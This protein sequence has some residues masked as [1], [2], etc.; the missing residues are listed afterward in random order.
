[1]RQETN[2]EIDLMLRRMSRRDGDSM[3]DEH[4]QFDDHHLDADELSSY[5]QNALPPATRARYTE[6]LAD[7]STCRKIATQLAL[8]LGTTV[9]ASAETVPTAGGLKAFLAGLFSPM[10]L[11]YAVPALGLIVV[12]VIGFVVLRQQGS[13]EMAS[14]TD[15]AE[16]KVPIVA[17]PK[18][19]VT[20]PLPNDSASKG[21][22]D[23]QNAQKQ[24]AQQP[25]SQQPR[26]GEPQTKSS[27]EAVGGVGGRPE[28]EQVQPEASALVAATPAPEP[29]KVAAAD[30]Q[31]EKREDAVAKK[32]PVAVAQSEA[33]PGAKDRASAPA[34]GNFVIAGDE[35]KAKAAPT[36]T[37]PF[38]AGK[39]PAAR[40][41][42]RARDEKADKEESTAATETRSIAGR[43]FR[44]ERGIW[45]D[46]EYDSSIRTVNMARGSEQFRALVADE[47]AIGSI[48]KQLNGEV[49]VV[50]K[51]R[52]Y[53]I[54]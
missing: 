40:A 34:T 5:A 15:L 43:T 20:T 21:F 26:A 35:N 2:N 30:R 7:C 38:I 52:A 4:T 44:N 6:H 1:M 48:A 41:A 47:P 39:A 36:E 8:S 18:P 49:I 46:T 29:P 42:K 33:T 12:T 16:K 28:K 3:G 32:Q 24:E 23:S 19:S 54:R 31:A 9:P 11:R 53:R 25:A 13:P 50:C 27:A 45:I 10:V 37:R 14:R 22:I 51:G 17:E